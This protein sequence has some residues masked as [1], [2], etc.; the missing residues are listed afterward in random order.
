MLILTTQKVTLLGAILK[1]NQ[2]LTWEGVP[3]HTSQH[4]KGTLL[5]L[6]IQWACEI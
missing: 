4:N 5:P 3:L 2:R 1:I 6:E